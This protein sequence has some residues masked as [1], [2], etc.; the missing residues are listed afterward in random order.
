MRNVV[1]LTKAQ[2]D[3]I[4]IRYHLGDSAYAIG[5]DYGIATTRVKRIATG[6]SYKAQTNYGPRATRKMEVTKLQETTPP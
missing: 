2:E 6:E 5:K 4:R 3:T 1:K